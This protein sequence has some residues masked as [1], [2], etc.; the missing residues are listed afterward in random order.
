MIDKTTKQ[1]IQEYTQLFLKLI[2]LYPNQT[3]FIKRLLEHAVFLCFIEDFQTHLKQYP[4]EY[5]IQFITL[6]PKQYQN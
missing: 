2:N 4:K 5:L 1:F 3:D 6:F